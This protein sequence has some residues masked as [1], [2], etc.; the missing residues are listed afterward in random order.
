[1]AKIVVRSSKAAIEKVAEVTAEPTNIISPIIEVAPAQPLKAKIRIKSREER[2]LDEL[3]QISEDLGLYDEDFAM[4]ERRPSKITIKESAVWVE[5]R[6]THVEILEAPHENERHYIEMLIHPDTSVS[7]TSLT[8][9]VKLPV[10]RAT[11]ALELHCLLIKSDDAL[12]ILDFWR[13]EQKIKIEY[14]PKAL[15]V[16]EI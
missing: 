16:G 14:D 13:D 4:D 5:G 10:R 6:F 3:V 7:W 8:Y 1:M 2:A 11:L 15:V 9:P 12:E